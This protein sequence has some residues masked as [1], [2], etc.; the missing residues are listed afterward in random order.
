MKP[1][2]VRPLF[3]G[4]VSLDG[5][6]LILEGDGRPALYVCAPS[7]SG[8]PRIFRTPEDA[9][10]TVCLPHPLPTADKKRRVFLPTGSRARFETEDARTVL[11]LHSV[12][13]ARELLE[14]LEAYGQLRQTY[15]AARAHFEGGTA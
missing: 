2:R 9:R 13:A 4:S 11:A 8:V 1:S 5:C 10:I 12:R 14:A 6:A 15:T 3:P 7:P